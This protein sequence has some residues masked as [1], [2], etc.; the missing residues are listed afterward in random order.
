MATKNSSGG[1]WPWFLLAL[2]AAAI[3]IRLSGQQLPETM[4]SHFDATGNANGFMARDTYLNFIT[5][6]AVG[7]PLLI[8]AVQ[9]LVLSQVAR[10]NIPNR[11]YWLAPE[12]RA[13]TLA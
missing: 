4:A 13:A 9:A 7:S 6:V 12:R 5:L 1:S 3:F 8:V 2:A 10:I 11:D